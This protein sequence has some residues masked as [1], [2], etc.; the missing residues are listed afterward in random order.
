MLGYIKCKRVK[1]MAYVT[2]VFILILILFGG[3]NIYNSYNIIN[4]QARANFIYLVE[5]IRDDE[6]QYFSSIEAEVL[7]CKRMIELT[8]DDIQLNRVAP[9]AYKYNKYQIPYIKNY[10]NSIIAPML[11]YS[12]KHIKDMVGIYFTFNYKLVKH[13]DLIGIWYTSPDFNDKFRLTD[14]GS[15]SDM[16][17]EEGNNLQWYFAPKKLKKG[18]WSEPYIDQDLKYGMITYSAP[19][20]SKKKFIG[21]I[22]ID[23][24]MDKTNHFI[25]NFKLYQTGRAY[26]LDKYKRIIF[27]KDYSM[28]TDSKVLDKNL[29][30]FLNQRTTKDGVKLSVNE[31][32]LIKSND[33][34]FAVTILYNGFILVIEVPIALLKGQTDKLVIFT[35]YSLILAILISMMIAIEAYAKIKKINN[36]LIH[37]EKLISIGTMAAEVAHEINNPLGYVNCNIDTL[38]KFIQKIKNLINSYEIALNKVLNKK[39]TIEDE[40]KYLSDLKEETKTDYVITS[41]DEII[42]ES[43]DGINKVSEIVV[44]IKN[45]AKDDS[46]GNKKDEKIEEIIEE[47]LAILN[48]RISHNIQ[49]IKYFKDIPPLYCNRNQIKQVL[50]NMIDNACHSL[51]EKENSDKQITVST[52]KKGENAYIEIEDNGIGIEKNKINKIFESFYTTKGQNGGTGL[53]LSISYEIITNKHKGEIQ[54]E[55]KKGCGTKFIIK[56]PY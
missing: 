48:K 10:L 17:R 33:K 55:S 18:I 24:A 50:I 32:K 21:I 37:K 49:I 35:S 16:Y 12:T 29:Y 38:K 46:L 52:Y 20:Y 41:I 28:L 27:S 34:L 11:L 31:I 23:V 42:K 8:I 7:N 6:N 39:S 1:L 36:E 9:I 53:G 45:F 4:K 3:V 13:E 5:N 40:I 14:N 43:K 44:R 30:N 26:L 2:I 51:N 25:R 56:I 54:V 15:T 47:S 22:G 19:V